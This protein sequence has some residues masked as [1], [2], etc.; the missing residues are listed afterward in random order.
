MAASQT[1]TLPPPLP[2]AI[3]LLAGL[4]DRLSKPFDSSVIKPSTLRSRWPETEFHKIAEVSELDMIAQPSWRHATVFTQCVWPSSSNNLSPVPVS[5]TNK[6][7]SYEPDTTLALSGLHAKL[8]TSQS[9]E[10]ISQ[11]FVWL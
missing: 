9:W 6:E 2:H 4:H 10:M 7:Q 8:V 11:I 1:S 5:H 3:W